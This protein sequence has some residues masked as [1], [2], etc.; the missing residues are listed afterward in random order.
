ML[1]NFVTISLTFCVPIGLYSLAVT[2]AVTKTGDDDNQLFYYDIFF[3][4]SNS[5]QPFQREG[6]LRTNIRTNFHVGI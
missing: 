6:V 5:V 4:K 2:L 3:Q 1:R